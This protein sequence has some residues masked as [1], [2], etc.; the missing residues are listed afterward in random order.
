MFPAGLEGQE[1]LLYMGWT[2]HLGCE[3]LA[4]L[5]GIP[6]PMP[7][8]LPKIPEKQ[9]GLR[10]KS[11]LGIVFMHILVNDTQYSSTVNRKSLD[12]LNTI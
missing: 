5:Q 10:L 7:Q 8:D 11:S 2:E 1:V 3:L 4:Q 6:F 12:N 9:E